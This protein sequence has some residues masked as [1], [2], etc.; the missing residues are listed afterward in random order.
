M[1]VGLTMELEVRLQVGLVLTEV[2]H[3]RTSHDG[4]GIWVAYF[5]AINLHMVMKRLD[6]VVGE[7]VADRA[8]EQFVGVVIAVILAFWRWRDPECWKFPWWDPSVSPQ[9]G[10]VL[11]GVGVP[12]VALLGGVPGG[13]PGK[14]GIGNIA[15]IPW[16]IANGGIPSGG[17]PGGSPAACIRA[18]SWPRTAIWLNW[19]CMSRCMCFIF[20]CRTIILCVCFSLVMWIRRFLATFVS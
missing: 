11:Q 17:K 1:L 8:L 15:C 7:D 9:T 13:G 12:G 14:P 3:V 10:I 19:N 5:T 18:G 6:W 4:Y 20:C 2:A 16:S